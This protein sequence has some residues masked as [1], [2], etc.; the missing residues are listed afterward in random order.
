G[1]FPLPIE[2]VIYG[3]KHLIS[4]FA[5]MNLNPVLRMKDGKPFITDNHNYIIDLHLK[6]TLDL[7]TLN[8]LK[9][10]S[11]VVETGLFLNK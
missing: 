8:D 7:K 6:A 2:V 5:E 9:T 4:R 1:A 10:I 3:Y 11:G